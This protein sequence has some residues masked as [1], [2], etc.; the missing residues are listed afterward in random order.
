[1]LTLLITV[2]VVVIIGAANPDKD[3][4]VSSE[5]PINKHNLTYYKMNRNLNV[6]INKLE[7]DKNEK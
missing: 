6:I 2:L 5:F 4:Q 7:K 3:K 1:M